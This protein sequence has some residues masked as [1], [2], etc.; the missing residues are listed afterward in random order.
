MVAHACNPCYSGGREQEDLYQASLGK[1][2][3]GHHL[4]KQAGHGSTCLKFWLHRRQRQ[5]C[6]LRPARGK[7]KK[8]QCPILK[9]TKV[10]GGMA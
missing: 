4:N 10:S 1:I 8:C 3:S 6:S 2:I 7:K 9:I 5:D